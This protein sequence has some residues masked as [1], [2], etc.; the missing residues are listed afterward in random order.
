[1]RDSGVDIVARIGMALHVHP[2]VML[3]LNVEITNKTSGPL[4]VV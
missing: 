1:M 4:I 3:S 2:S